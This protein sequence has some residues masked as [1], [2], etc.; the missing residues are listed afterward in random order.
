MTLH[1]SSTPKS[2]EIPVTLEFTM[3]DVL[4]CQT[5]KNNNKNNN[6]SNS[7]NTNTN[8]NSHPHV[9]NPPHH[10]NN[11]IKH[12][13]NSLLNQKNNNESSSPHPDLILPVV[14]DPNQNE[15]KG[16]NRLS[17]GEEEDEQEDAHGR[18]ISDENANE[19]RTLD[20]DKVLADSL[21]RIDNIHH[22]VIVRGSKCLGN[23]EFGDISSSTPSPQPV[24][25]ARRKKSILLEESKAR[26]EAAAVATPPSSP[27]DERMPSRIPLSVGTVP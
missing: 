20:K 5:N 6:N 24:V 1:A 22:V 3:T 15:V 7:N 21:E 8:N 18:D 25:D 2:R 27:S 14:E 26:K 9:I 12:N 17:L 23:E 4:P 16:P 19:S 11:F 10:N 13:N